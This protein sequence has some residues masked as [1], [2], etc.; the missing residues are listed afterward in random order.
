[1]NKIKNNTNLIG[2]V[3]QDPDIRRL[4]NGSMVANFSL[5]TNESY[6]DK[7]GE[8]QTE[9]QWHRIVAWGKLAEYVENKIKKGTE[10]AVSGKLKY[11]KYTN[12]DGQQVTIANIVI[13]QILV[14]SRGSQPEQ[15]ST[16]FAPINPPNEEPPANEF[17]DDLP[18]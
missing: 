14:L 6:K 16:P 13:D 2:H 1:M 17:D 8:W 11:Q 5:A 12:R 18:F 15:T 3:G 7:S 9:T 4:E 10:C